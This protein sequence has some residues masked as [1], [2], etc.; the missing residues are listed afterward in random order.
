MKSHFFDSIIFRFIQVY[1]ISVLC[2]SAFRFI[3][4]L[5]ELDKIAPSTGT[6]NIFYSFFMGVRFDIVICGYILILPFFIFSIFYILNKEN[7]FLK[8]L[9]IKY[10]VFIFFMAFLV[11]SI[12]I[13]YFNQFFSRFSVSA[14]QWIYHS[15]EFVIKMIIQEPRYWFPLIPLVLISYLFIKIVVPILNKPIY[16]TKQ[17]IGIKMIISIVFL[18]MILLGIR[19]RLDEKS[20]IRIGTAYFS[21]NSFLNQLGLN[22]NFTLIRSFLDSLKDENK[23]IDLIDTSIAISNVQNYLS[24]KPKDS[25]HPIDRKIVAKWQNKTQYNVVLILME[26]MSAAKLARHGN[27]K[28][29]TPFLDSISHKGYYFENTYSAG[30]HTFNGIFSSLFSFPALFRQHPL[31]NSWTNNYHS[32][33]SILNANNYSTLY[34]TTHDGQFDNVEGFLKQNDCETIIS[35]ENYPSKEIKTTLGVPDDYMFGFSIPI[36]DEQSAKNK[37]FFAT[38]MTASDHGPYYLPEY[39]IPKNTDIKDQIVEYADYSLRKFIQESSKKKWF[40]NTIFVFIADHGSVMDTTYNMSLSYNHVPLLFYAPNII[41]DHKTIENMAGQ[42]DVF[43]TI[44]GLLPISYTNNT[45]GIDL[46]KEKRPYIFFNADDKYGVIDKNWFLEVNQD[47]SLKLYQYHTK[48]TKDFSAQ[49][50][51]VVA[52]MNNYAKSNLQTYQHL[53]NQNKFAR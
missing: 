25:I 11:C 14:F 15:P 44:L 26:S 46:L 45:L 13:P 6:F 38:F 7:S 24:I 4:F 51:N 53:L 5:T 33:Y 28:N 48:N 19:G 12:D 23:K 43:P 17:S 8:S 41:L 21:N 16:S 29:L 10:I 36:L 47:K 52:K 1:I 18:G 30:I 27:K 35:K 49:H 31:K 20:P 3:L 37:P 34:F 22:P 42:I 40:K 2:F 9:T 32:I 50:P 39:F